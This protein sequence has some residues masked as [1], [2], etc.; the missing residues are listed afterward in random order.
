MSAT[1][2]SPP[3]A[4]APV[5]TGSAGRLTRRRAALVAGFGYLAIF[6]LALFANFVVLEGLVVADDGEATVANIADDT[7]LF[8][9]GLVAF[10]VVFVL[11]VVIAWALHVVF[12][13]RE[14]DLSRLAAWLRLTYTAF[15]GV[16]LVAFFVV[17]QLVGGAE[18]LAAFDPDQIASQAML[19]LDAFE[20][21]WLIG[22][23]AFGLHLVVVGWMILRTGAASPLLGWLLTVA[24][25]AYMIDTAA[26]AVLP[27]YDDLAGLFLALVAVPSVVAELWLGIWLLRGGGGRRVAPDE[28]SETTA[29]AA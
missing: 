26:H 22:L 10:L 17:L 19:A 3:L 16:G 21:A 28:R 4:P 23:V 12:R 25:T 9:A 8:R 15:L 5:A 20:A 11:D 14:P 2:V 18:H 1:A 7:A 24:G 27:G 6:V 29:L 13:D